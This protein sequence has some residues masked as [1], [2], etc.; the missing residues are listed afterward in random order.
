MDRCNHPVDYRF[1]RDP[2]DR[3]HI[4][5][6]RSLDSQ[7]LDYSFGRNLA[8]DCNFDRSHDRSHFECFDS[9]SD[10][11][12]DVDTDLLSASGSSSA[13]VGNLFDCCVH[14]HLH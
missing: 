1:D 9:D 14:Y 10:S 7:N 2:V 12:F 11:D 4:L 5:V 8:A 13:G 3:L 6:D